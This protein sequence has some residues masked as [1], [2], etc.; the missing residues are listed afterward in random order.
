[1]KK[2]ITE[3]NHLAWQLIEHLPSEIAAPI[4]TSWEDLARRAKVVVTLFGPYDT[5]KSSL[6][7]RLLLD[8][9]LPV[10]E[11]LTISALRETFEVREAEACSVIIRDTPGVSGGNTLHEA[12][13]GDALFLTDAIVVMLPPQLVTGDAAALQVITSVL[14]GSH[15]NC[16]SEEAFAPGS[17]LLVLAR[18]DGAGAM[19][20][21]DLAGYEALLKRKRSELSS[22]LARAKVPEPLLSIHA[23]VAD[24]S[25]MTGSSADVSAADY[26]GSRAWDGIDALSA[27]LESLSS[28]RDELRMWSERRFLRAHLGRVQEALRINIRDY[29]LARES[30]ANEGEAIALQEARLNTLLGN[31]NASLQNR[32]AEEVQAISQRGDTKPEVVK[33]MLSERIQSSLRRWWDAQDA[34]LQILLEEIDAEIQQRH[35]RPDWQAMADIIEGIGSSTGASDENEKRGIPRRGDVLRTAEMF[36]KTYSEITPVVLGMPTKKAREELGRLR[37]AGSFQEYAKR[38]VRR[39]GAFKDPSHADKAKTMLK[40]DA[41]ITV[42]IPIIVELAGMVAEHQAEERAAEQ[43]IARRAKLQASLDSAAKS[44]VEETW[45]QWHTTGMASVMVDA[46]ATA[47]SSAS[48]RSCFLEQQIEN[49]KLAIANI[50]EVLN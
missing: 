8:A 42:A 18:M 37:Q 31:A 32:V 7:K 40:V 25:G 4:R 28:R 20:D 27:D 45:S 46:L 23:I 41:T 34:A 9:S 50:T 49:A 47:H 12:A 35:A 17:L 43:R 24:W 5:G 15:Y 39:K 14:D 22:F 10:P 33:R 30:S 16:A 19:P 26:D 44:I 48:Q 6:L 13:T 11:W 21:I 38:S 36:K 3:W 1:M 29:E 2:N